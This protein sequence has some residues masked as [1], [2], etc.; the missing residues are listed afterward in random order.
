MGATPTRCA[1]SGLVPALCRVETVERCPSQ[2]AWL[3]SGIAIGLMGGS[4]LAV[5]VT[6][7]P[8]PQAQITG[9]S[10]PCPAP[11]D[12]LAQLICATPAL[13]RFD[14]LFVQTYQALR[15]Q[16]ADPA[17]QQA[18]R[19]EAVDLGLAVR[20]SCGI[21][22]AQSAN[23]K[24]PPPPTAPPGA[25]GCVF[26]AYERQ[27][28]IWQS[29]LSGAAA[30]EATRSMDQQ[31]KLQSA[32]QQLGFLALADPVDGVFGTATRAAITAWQTSTGRQVTGLLGNSDAQALVQPSP[33]TATPKSDQPIVA[34]ME[35]PSDVDTVRQA[36]LDELKTRFGQHAE[37][38]IA[39]DVQMGMTTAEVLEAKGAPLREESFPPNY[40]LWVYDSVRIAFTD[41]KVTHVGH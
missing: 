31:I 27:R 15:Q 38:I 19:Q 12:P 24:A 25:S 34:L 23:S 11:R 26:Q 35:R 10:F 13:S 21:A 8:S 4:L 36:R 14:L 2:T 3:A 1:K 7:Q 30:E 41:G 33:E 20:S 37:A 22:V 39:G 5:P 40:A 18:V 17:A 9:P 32:L 28:A 6:A 16:A 29:R